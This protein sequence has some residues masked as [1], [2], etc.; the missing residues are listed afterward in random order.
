MSLI[1]RDLTWLTAEARNDA[2]TAQQIIEALAERV[3]TLQRQ[4]DELRAE[5]ALL[6]RTGG[7]QTSI[8]QVSRLKT[9]LRDLRSLAER[10]GLN[11]DVISM[12]AFSGHG[13]QLAAPAPLE[14]TLTVLTSP[15]EPIDALKPLYLASGTW[16]GSLLAVTSNV[17]F[18]IVNGL[19]LRYSDKLDWRDARAIS[20][21]GLARAE[22]VEAVCALDDLHPPRALLLVTR[23]GWLRVMS[24]SHAETILLSGQSMTLPGTGDSPVWIGPCDTDADILLLT[25]NGRWTRFPVGMVPSIGC[26]G[27]ALDQDDDV[28]AAVVLSRQNAPTAVWF[29]GSDG[30]L[31]ALSTEGLAPHKKPGAKPAPLSRRFPGLACYG[32]TAHKKELVA[33]LSNQGDLHIVSM[34]GLPVASKPAEI[35]PLKVSSQRIIAAT[36]L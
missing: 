28:A 21:L 25:R 34:K 1:E 17:R 10:K 11:R 27:V 32:V 4:A 2:D 12:V 16:F 13:V 22:R 8:E 36:L 29:I 30:S 15:D 31:F 6:K 7:Q 24:W 26:S 3:Q 23:Q 14:Q 9:S 18:A 20:G 5:T 19:S 35:Q 33:L